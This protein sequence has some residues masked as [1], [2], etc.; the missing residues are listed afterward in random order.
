MVEMRE[1][2]RAAEGKVELAPS[3]THARTLHTAH[4]DA[5]T[6]VMKSRTFEFSAALRT[7]VKG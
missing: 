3:H 2:K 4:A 7:P 5:H 6:H 1:A